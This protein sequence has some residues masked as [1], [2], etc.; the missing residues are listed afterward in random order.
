MF[1]ASGGAASVPVSGLPTTPLALRRTQAPSVKH[2]EFLRKSG[3]GENHENPD[4]PSDFP[5]VSRRNISQPIVSERK[6]NREIPFAENAENRKCAKMRCWSSTSAGCDDGERLSASPRRERPGRKTER[7]PVLGT[8]GRG[9]PHR[10]LNF[11]GAP[12]DATRSQGSPGPKTRV[13]E[14][15]ATTP[16][17]RAARPD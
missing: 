4:R 10:D 7:V 17:R 2:G 8:S 9:A 15:E 11:R 12:V 1:P 5:R 3:V 6:L 16:C 13:Q 14:K